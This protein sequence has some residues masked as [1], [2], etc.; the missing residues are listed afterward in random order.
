MN[1]QIPMYIRIYLLMSE[2]PAHGS[3]GTINGPKWVQ[4]TL[5]GDLFHLMIEK[6]YYRFY[7]GEV[8]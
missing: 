7:W 8:L 1:G 3:V 4:H 5:A 2:S 6:K